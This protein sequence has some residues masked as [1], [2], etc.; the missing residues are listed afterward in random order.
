MSRNRPDRKE[1]RRAKALEREHA[2]LVGIQGSAKPVEVTA[3]TVLELMTRSL[4]KGELRQYRER[5][6]R[7]LQS[8]LSSSEKKRLADM[9]HSVEKD[10]RSF[11][12]RQELDSSAENR[13]RQM[14]RS[15]K[16]VR[17]TCG[18]GRSTLSCPACQLDMEEAS[19]HA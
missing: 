6:I 10:T 9:V 12:A 8:R 2:R 3:K 11:V 13:S 17:H 7:D 1:V 14:G 5:K 15:R 16:N 18:N 4:E 19:R